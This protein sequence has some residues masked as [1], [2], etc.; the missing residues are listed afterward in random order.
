MAIIAAFVDC[1]LVVSYLDEI[2]ETQIGS[3]QSGVVY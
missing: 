3:Q 2:P 1:V